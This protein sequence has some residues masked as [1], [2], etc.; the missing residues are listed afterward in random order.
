MNKREFNKILN[1][2]RTKNKEFL[3]LN[4]V[5]QLDD[6]VKTSLSL[7]ILRQRGPLLINLITSE[8]SPSLNVLGYMH[9]TQSKTN[10]QFTF[11]HTCEHLIK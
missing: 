11:V 2:C 1:S 6:S 3:D 5:K 8:I 4:K 9:T 10:P 7:F